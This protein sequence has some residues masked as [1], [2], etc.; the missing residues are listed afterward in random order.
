M[1]SKERGGGKKEDGRGG[2]EEKR[3]GKGKKRREGEKEEGRGTGRE[4][5]K[6]VIAQKGVVLLPHNFSFSASGQNT[7]KTSLKS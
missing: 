6:G 1:F 5:N 4:E 7:K 2:R 3:G